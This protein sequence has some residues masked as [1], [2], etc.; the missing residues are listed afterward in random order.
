MIVINVKDLS[1]TSRDISCPNDGFRSLRAIVRSDGVGFSLNKTIIPPG[2]PQRWHY[3]HHKEACYCVS[4][5]GV[6]LNENDGC[7]WSIEPGVLYVLDDNDPHT[8]QAYTEVVLISVFSPA[9][10]GGEIHQADG[11]YPRSDT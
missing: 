8:F 5:K 11:S 10:E 6:L 3:K 2:E 7:K 9:L 4:G 1:G